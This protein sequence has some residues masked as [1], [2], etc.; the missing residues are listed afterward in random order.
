MRSGRV[1]RKPGYDGEYGVIRVFEEGELARLAGQGSLFGE[2][3]TVRRAR[4]ETQALA[5][6]ALAASPSF[7]G[8]PG[9]GA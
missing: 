6:P 8:R 1:I 9:R 7:R 5:L 2:G 3:P 4:K